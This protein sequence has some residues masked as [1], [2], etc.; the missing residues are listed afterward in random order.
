MTLWTFELCKRPKAIGAFFLQ[1]MRLAGFPGLYF[2]SLI[3]P[4]SGFLMT[5]LIPLQNYVRQ[6]HL[7][8]FIQAVHRL[9][10]GLG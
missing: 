5:F 6:R 1:S 4:N 3:D 9:I 7:H 8:P 10:G 2:D